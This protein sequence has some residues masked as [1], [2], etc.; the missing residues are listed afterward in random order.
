MNIQ[1]SLPAALQTAGTTVLQPDKMA[2]YPPDPSYGS[3]YREQNNNYMPSYDQQQMDLSNRHLAP[4]LNYPPQNAPD[5]FAAYNMASAQY[6]ANL[7]AFGAPS[8]SPAP[9]A[10]NA[11]SFQ[12]PPAAWNASAVMPSKPMGWQQQ[13]PFNF[14]QPSPVPYGLPRID[15][16]SH[17]Q[18]PQQQVD[19]VA[20]PVED[21]ELSEGEFQDNFGGKVSDSVAD[22]NNNMSGS[23]YRDSNG[24]RSNASPRENVY[25]D[26]PRSAAPPNGRRSGIFPFVSPNL[27]PGS[28]L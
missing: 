7:P 4:N 27:S 8:F 5:S 3:N 15:T 24:Y 18:V 16:N 9:Y 19:V 17:H 23:Y 20:Q 28:S 6:N 12:M 26:S 1:P 2:G 21:G 13:Q 11:P 14:A 10:P 25:R 22:A